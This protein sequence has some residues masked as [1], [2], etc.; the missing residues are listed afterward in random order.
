MLRSLPKPRPKRSQSFL[1]SPPT[2]SGSASSRASIDPA[3]ISLALISCWQKRPENALSCCSNWY[4]RLRRSLTSGTRP[5]LFMRK[6][7]KRSAGCGA[8]S[9]GTPPL[10]KCK[11]ANRDRDGLCEL[12][13]QRVDAIH[14]AAD[15]FLLTHLDQ[16]VALAARHS[17]PAVYAFRQ[18]VTL[19]GLIELWN[20]FPSCLAPSGRLHRPHSQG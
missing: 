20:G 1:C 10:R 18:A 8:R 4:L 2:P 17:V 6:R 9:W 15:G 16:I 11:S 19:G 7:R 3:E 12:V 5:I 13:Q 14:V